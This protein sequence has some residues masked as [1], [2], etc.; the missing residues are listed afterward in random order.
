[1]TIRHINYTRL[2]NFLCLFDKFKAGIEWNARH[3]DRADIDRFNYKVVVP[4]ETAWAALTDDEKDYIIEK[5]T[6]QAPTTV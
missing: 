4:M 5:T 1:M 2:N 6:H 3:H